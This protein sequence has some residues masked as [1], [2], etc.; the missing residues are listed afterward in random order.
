M[1]K[2]TKIWIGVGIVLILLM[3]GIAVYATKSDGATQPPSP[4]GPNPSSGN[5]TG[6]VNI[7]DTFRNI[8]KKITNKSDFKQTPP[9]DENGCDVNGY[10]AIGV[11]CDI[12]Y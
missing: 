4:V 5:S 2:S 7:L 9:I 8:I 10:N 6:S 3:I 12:G 1:E 11:K